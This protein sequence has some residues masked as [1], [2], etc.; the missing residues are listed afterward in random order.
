MV[1][2][3]YGLDLVNEDSILVFEYYTATGLDGLCISSEAESLITS[4]VDDIKDEDIYL[5][6]SEK[7][8]YISDKYPSVKTIIL[9]MSLY[10]WL[11]DYASKF[12]R[13]FFISSE[14]DNNL[15]KLT[16]LL[17]K[18]NI[19]VYGSDSY[20]CKLCSDKYETYD[21]LKGKI[22]E[23]ETHKILISKKTYWNRVIG[24]LLKNLNSEDI[25]EKY[26]DIDFSKLDIKTKLIVKPIDG[27]DCEDIKIISSKEDINSLT[28]VF[29]DGSRVIVQ[30]YIEGEIL[31][32]SLISDGRNSIPLSLNKQFVLLENDSHKYLGGQV[33]YD[34]PLKEEIFEKIIKAVDCIPGLKGFF[35]VDFILSEDGEVY[36]LEINS[37]FT[38]PYVAL[39][40]ISDLNIP[41]SIL[42]LL[43]GLITI[44][45]IKS[46]IS[47]NNSVRFQKKKGL[48]NFDFDI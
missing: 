15:F 19:K 26:E 2:K 18:N 1:N 48:L 11:K 21:F 5:L 33:P 22:R 46:N 23:P 3:E 7:Y 31:S 14:E 27:V 6:L 44:E 40:K 20:A 28:N 43:D 12:K 9:D 47:F 13:A 36:L 42:D 41:K 45:D 34:H 16:K 10:D 37:R 25:H 38:T 32:L 35:G 17:E 24:I 29:E 30:E 39:S 8:A 4:L